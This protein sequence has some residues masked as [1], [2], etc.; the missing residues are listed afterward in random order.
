MSWQMIEK[1]RA[2][3]KVSPSLENSEAVRARF[4]WEEA[5]RA[6]DGL[7]DGRRRIV[8][9]QSRSVQGTGRTGMVL[10][11]LSTRRRGGS[12][13]RSLWGSRPRAALRTPRKKGT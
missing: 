7:P 9:S 2:V 13:C 12:E 8:D 6:L 1:H 4:S 3:T 10:A 11:K 5:R